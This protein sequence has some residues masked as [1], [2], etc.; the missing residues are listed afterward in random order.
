M[1][2]FVKYRNSLSLPSKIL[3]KR[4]PVSLGTYKSIMVFVKLAFSRFS[5]YR[6]LGLFLKFSPHLELLAKPTKISSNEKP[7]F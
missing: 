3:H 6:P 2:F 4:F 5:K 1:V 7:Y